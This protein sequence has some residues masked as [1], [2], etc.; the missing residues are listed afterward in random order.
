[1]NICFLLFSWLGSLA[2][3]DYSF[4]HTW[5]SPGAYHIPFILELEFPP[6]VLTMVSPIFSHENTLTTLKI[7][8][9]LN[10]WHVHFTEII[11]NFELE[12]HLCGKPQN[13]V[14]LSLQVNFRP[15]NLDNVK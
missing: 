8:Y 5:K 7:F 9:W 15:W 3:L 4:V 12:K 13:Y 6:E 11:I 14:D 10:Q 2:D 1:M